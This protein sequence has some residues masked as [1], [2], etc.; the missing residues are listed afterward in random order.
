MQARPHFIVTEVIFCAKIKDMGSPIGLD[1]QLYVTV[2]AMSQTI[3]VM[4]L[5]NLLQYYN[6]TLYVW[7]RL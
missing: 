1:V 6:I 3:A 2:V 7:K 5:N 4:P